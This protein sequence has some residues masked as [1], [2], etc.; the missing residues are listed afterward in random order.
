MATVDEDEGVAMMGGALPLA[1]VADQLTTV[2]AV[3]V[4]A[5]WVVTC[6]LLWILRKQQFAQKAREEAAQSSERLAEK[7]DQMQHALERLAAEN[8]AIQAE[9]QQFADRLN[10]TQQH[11]VQFVRQVGEMQA[12]VTKQAE[13]LATLQSQYEDLAKAQR[14]D[15]DQVVALTARLISGPL[16]P[17]SVPGF[18]VGAPSS[19]GP[20]APGGESHRP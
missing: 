9:R 20:H 8:L 14:S 15:H 16:G 5:V 17:A 10:Q 11:A 3:T 13:R 6:A 19:P 12:T 7:M 1:D 4:A 2:S 18:G